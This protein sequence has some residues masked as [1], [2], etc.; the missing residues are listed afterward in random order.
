MALRQNVSKLFTPKEK[1]ESIYDI[2]L[3][4]LYKRGVRGI[5]FDIENTLLSPASDQPTLK[6]RQWLE[7]A[8]AQGFKLCMLSNDRDPKRVTQLA[9]ALQVP[10]VHSALKP[11]PWAMENAMVE[12]L[13]LKPQEVAVIGDTIITD[14]LPGNMLKSHTILVEPI[15]EKDDPLLHWLTRRTGEALMKVITPRRK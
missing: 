14:V 6:C 7:Q 13:E 1:L 11:F 5:V 15:S 10:A 12:V 8:K 2:N 4:Y 3:G 9:E